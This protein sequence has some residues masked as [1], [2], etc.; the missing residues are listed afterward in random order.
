MSKDLDNLSVAFDGLYSGE[1]EEVV[2]E[3]VAEE[4][5]EKEIE[6]AEEAKTEEKI[7]AEDIKDIEIEEQLND[8]DLDRKLSG[9]PKEFRELV[10]SVKDAETR[11]KILEAGKIARAREDRISSELGNLRKES[12]NVRD[13]ENLLKTDPQQ[14]LKNLAKAVKVD[15]NSLIDRPVLSEDDYDYRTN[16]EILRDNEFQDIKQ[17]IYSLENA[18]KEQEAEENFALINSFETEKDS[19]GNLKRP[20]FDKV[21]QHLVDIITLENQRIGF[22][23]TTNERLE[24]LERAYKKAVLLDDDL[25]SERDEEILRTAE[26]KRREMIENAKKLK[27]FG[28]S[29]NVD[30]TKVLTPLEANSIA[31]SKL[32]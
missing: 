25:I 30:T 20:H 22:A 11:D 12:A 15:L 26:E 23:K 10:K 6:A 29:I 13:F 18:K 5:K 1:T 3:V 7:S 32:F 4:P 2:E 17:K 27:K 31:L 19:K 21:Y 14:A 8:S 28:R 9:Q 16:E 24:R